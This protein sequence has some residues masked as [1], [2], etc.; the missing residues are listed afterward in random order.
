MIV[1]NLSIKHKYTNKPIIEKLNLIVNDSDKV[2]II[3]EEGNGKSTLLKLMANIDL[4]YIEMSG[5]IVYQ[6]KV[7]YLPQ[8]MDSGWHGQRV[9]DFFVKEHPGSEINIENYNRFNKIEEYF[10]KF[11]LS[12]SFDQLIESI[13]GG[14]KIKIQLIKLVLSS[15]DIFLLDEPSNDL[16]LATIEWLERFIKTSKKPVVYISHDEVLLENTATKIVHLELVKK[17]N[18]TRNT[19]VNTDYTSYYNERLNK[20]KKQTMEAYNERREHRKQQEKFKRIYEKVE[21]QQNAITRQDP[22]GARLLAKKIKAMK[23]VERRLENP[24][25]TDIPVVEEAIQIKFKETK[26]PNVPIVNIDL[27]ELQ[28]GERVLANDI[29]LI[30]KGCEKIVITGRNGSGKTTL[31]KHILNELKRKDFRVGY[32]PQDYGSDLNYELTGTE[33]LLKETVHDST[34]VK[35]YLGSAKFT[36]EEMDEPIGNYSGGQ[37]AKLF[38]L[39]LI[40]N[41]S[42]VLI[43]DEPTRNL[44][45]LSNPVIRNILKEFDGCIISVSHDR[46]FIKEVS[47]EIYTL[48]KKLKK[49][50]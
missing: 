23:S 48:D 21:H 37:K 1:N 34:T 43:L 6:K 38:L 15:P 29:E 12:I 17:K 36:R 28:I 25:F 24:D 35:Q 9:E 47:N 4:D 45:P 50:N 13:S 27:K 11:D 22:A 18:E 32:F 42:N 46:K 14:E 2:A 7:G 16:D 8:S 31:L 39:K 33:W 3:G 44:S 20:I 10:G 40:L 26:L 30:V 41:E 49:V 5:Q 19:V